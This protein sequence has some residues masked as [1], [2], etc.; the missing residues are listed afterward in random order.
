FARPGR[1]QV[2]CSHLLPVLQELRILMAT[3]GNGVAQLVISTTSWVG[4]FKILASFG[5]TA[6]AGYTVAMRLVM[7]ALLPA[8]GLANAGAT[9]VGQN[10]GAGHAQ[11][12]EQA[13]RIAARY[14]IM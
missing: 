8:W 7:F 1:V 14:N 12:A 13:I 10:L 5:S 4:L 2:R 9:L 6:L 3:A 11:R